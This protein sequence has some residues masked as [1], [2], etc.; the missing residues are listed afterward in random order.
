MIRGEISVNFIYES[1]NFLAFPDANP[2]VEGHTLLIPKDHFVNLMDLP[3][4]L[5]RELLE[6]I[7]AVAEMRLKEGFGGFNIV[8][9]NFSAA[10]Q[11]VMHS[12]VH[13]LPRKK[14]DGFDLVL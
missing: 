6:G 11:M 3:E 1:D 5:G 13:I 8:C 9:N 12:H 14:N 10:G 2:K 7:K 4:S